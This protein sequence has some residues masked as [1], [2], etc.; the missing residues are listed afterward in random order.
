MNEIVEYRGVEGLVYAELLSDTAEGIEYGEVKPLAGVASVS[1]TTESSSESHYYDNGPMVVVSSTGPDTITIA[2]SALDL[3]TLADITGQFYDETTGM[4][5]EGER[6]PKYYAV[7]YKTKKT[8]G[9]YVYVWRLK[10]QFGIPDNEHVTEDD[11][12]DANGQELVYTG[13]NTT[14]KFTKLTD[15]NHPNGRT[16]KAVNVDLGKDLADVSTFFDAVTTPDTL[17]AKG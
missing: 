13:I 8:N 17:K 6:D 16:A 1:K 9:K 3:E 5:V 10:G 12:N 15:S 2:A 14:H 7:G 4:F 11:G